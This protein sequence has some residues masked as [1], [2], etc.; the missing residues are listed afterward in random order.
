MPARGAGGV[1]EL[2][3][4]HGVKINLAI[5]AER[6]VARVELWRV[7]GEGVGGLECERKWGERRRAMRAMREVDT[8]HHTDVRTYNPPPVKRA[9]MHSDQTNL[10]EYKSACA[11]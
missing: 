10:A 11:S 3:V 1:R 2:R 6:P 8:W 7:S 9:H 4:V 5:V